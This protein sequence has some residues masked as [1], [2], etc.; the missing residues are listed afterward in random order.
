MVEVRRVTGRSRGLRWPLVIVW[1]LALAN[2]A[3]TAFLPQS[4]ARTYGVALLGLSIGCLV[5]VFVYA[6]GL[7]ADTSAAAARTV[8]LIGG[9]CDGRLLLDATSDLPSELWLAGRDGSLCS[10]RVSSVR[11]SGPQ[12]MLYQR[13]DVS[14]PSPGQ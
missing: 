9:P 4:A 10:Y 12:T 2:L 1:L 7:R 6:R 3:A 5:V 13:T 14:R 8:L 11:T